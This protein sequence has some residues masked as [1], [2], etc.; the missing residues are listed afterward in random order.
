MNCLPSHVSNC[1]RVSRLTS[2]TY[3]F[4]QGN[5]ISQK[6]IGEP[7]RC[8][9]LFTGNTVDAV[10][11][12]VS[13]ESYFVGPVFHGF[14][15]K[16]FGSQLV[17]ALKQVTRNIWMLGMNGS[18]DC[19]A[20]HDRGCIF[21]PFK[22]KVLFSCAERSKGC[23]RQRGWCFSSLLRG[24]HNKTV[25]VDISQSDHRIVVEFCE[26]AIKITKR[27]ESCWW[28]YNRYAY[29]ITASAAN[30]SSRRPP[31]ARFL[32]LSNWFCTKKLKSNINR[33]AMRAG[34]DE[35]SHD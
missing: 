24:P 1:W 21:A 19:P 6:R 18:F 30:S 7:P 4:R 8:R 33:V 27:A 23:V 17:Y 26:R 28:R 34:S 20:I 15:N 16:V 11:A 3:L 9:K 35:L 12:V 32:I 31:F 10:R 25:A 5:E 29:C 13:N 14:W 2:K 22:M